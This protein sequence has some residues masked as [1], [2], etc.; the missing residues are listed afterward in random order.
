MEGSFTSQGSPVSSQLRQDLSLLIN[1]CDEASQSSGGMHGIVNPDTNS[2]SQSAIVGAFHY[3]SPTEDD[4]APSSGT[5]TPTEGSPLVSKALLKS[6]APS[7]SSCDSSSIESREDDYPFEITPLPMN[8]IRILLFGQLPEPLVASVLFPFINELVGLV[9]VTG[10]D[11]RKIGYYAGLVESLFFFAE[12]CFI[13]HWGRLSDRIGRKPVLIIG[14]MGLALSI[15]SFGLSTTYTGLVVS[16]ALA[17][18]LSGNVGVFKSVMGEIT[19]DTN[20]AE[21]FAMMPV[22]WSAGSTLGPLIGGFF[23]RPHDKF[24]NTF[25]SQFWRDYPY[26]LPCMIVGLICLL[27]ALV[28]ALFLEESLPRLKKQKVFDD[29]D[30]VAVDSSPHRVSH[31]R[32]PSEETLVEPAHVPPPLSKILTR[33]VVI[34]ISNYCTIALLDIA[35][36]ALMPLF[37]ATPVTDGGLGLP[38][39]KIGVVL[40]TLGL[41][42]GIFQGLFSAKAQRYFG[43]KALFIFGVSSYLVAY[44][45]F[46]VLNTLARTHGVGL[47]VYTVLL[48]Q[49]LTTIS[50]NMSFGCV[51]LFITSAAEKSSLGATN[52]VAQTVVSFMRTVGPAAATSIFAFSTEKN[53]LGGNLVYYIFMTLTFGA[54]WVGTLLPAKAVRGC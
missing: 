32:S 22:M 49:I 28:L 47:L 44:A 41:I 17:G 11:D 30:Y 40:G 24:P 6:K 4:Y 54:I 39:A 19:D 35:Y 29:K 45:L 50:V 8:Q 48:I 33:K 13:L 38:P 1:R 10:G 46:P 5:I 18:I 2:P 26:F 53:L 7:Y 14:L 15:T 12:F 20:I 23:S 9:G 25:S 51:F 52:G 43:I 16:R 37:Y 27:A 34:A 31:G 42:N 21:G 36:T 3:R